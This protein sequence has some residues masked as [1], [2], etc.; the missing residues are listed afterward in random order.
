M[1]VA[2]SFLFFYMITNSQINAQEW[3]CKRNFEINL[4]NVVSYI[5]IDLVPLGTIFYLQWKNFRVESQKQ[6]MLEK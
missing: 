4:L 1:V 3:V 6:Y 2:R 5:I